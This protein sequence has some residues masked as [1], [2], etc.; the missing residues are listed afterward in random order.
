[1]QKARR[2]TFPLR[3]IVLRLFVGGMVSGTISLP[4]RGTFHLSL[5]VL[6][7]Y[8]WQRVFSLRRWSAQIHARLLVSRVTW[9]RNGSQ[10]TFAYR[11]ITL[12]GRPFQTFWLAICFVT[13]R[14]SLQFC[15]SLPT[16]PISQR[17]HPIS[18]YRFRLFRFRSPL[19]T[20]SL[21]FLFLG[22]LRC[23]S[24]PTYLPLNEDDQALPW[25]GFPIRESPDLRMF[26]PPRSLSQLAAPFI[27]SLPQGIHH[28]PFVA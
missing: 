4:S 18:R 15:Q 3:D 8:R 2:Y 10:I 6:V 17:L 24:S 11:A 14:H 20:E 23:F 19:L 26:V 13:S 28:T 5:A 1:M 7:H 12:C 27:G 16:T 9:E 21:R 22:L 25:P